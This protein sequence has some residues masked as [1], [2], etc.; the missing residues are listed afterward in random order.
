MSYCLPLYFLLQTGKSGVPL[1]S[2]P[3]ELCRP[4][5]RGSASR[6]GSDSVWEK[7]EDAEVPARP[8]DSLQQQQPAGK[9]Q[10]ILNRCRKTVLCQWDCFPPSVQTVPL[11]AC[12]DLPTVSLSTDTIDFGFCYVA[13]TKT[14]EVDLHSQGTYIYWTS[15]IGEYY[16]QCWQFVLGQT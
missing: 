8:P 13:R 1:H 6:C 16:I 4:G 3:S 14:V 9:R 7:S 15:V 12:L 2:A 11:Q 5:R 10:K